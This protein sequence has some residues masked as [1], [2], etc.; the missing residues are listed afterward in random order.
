MRH[1]CPHHLAFVAQSDF[2]DLVRE[3]LLEPLRKQLRQH[4]PYDEVAPALTALGETIGRLGEDA[5]ALV[6]KQEDSVRR[7]QAARENLQRR[8]EEF[9]QQCER[10]DTSVGVISSNLH[11]SNDLTAQVGSTRTELQHIN[12]QVQTIRQRLAQFRESL[13]E[14]PTTLPNLGEEEQKEE[15]EGSPVASDLPA[16]HPGN[17]LSAAEARMDPGQ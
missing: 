4:S 14:P 8:R 17:L 15:E 3:Q 7:L 2:I 1:L 10:I 13:L 6:R 16:D 11:A 9:K 5:Q 12:T